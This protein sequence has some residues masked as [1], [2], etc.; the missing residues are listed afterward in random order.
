MSFVCD[1]LEG[2]PPDAIVG[3]SS[4]RR[5]VLLRSELDRLGRT[6]VRIEPLR[7]NLDTRL[8]KLDEGQ[9]HAIVLAAAGLQRLGL[10]SR[11]RHIF[12]PDQSLPAA[13]QGALG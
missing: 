4:L 7:G 12:E 8:R 11:I 6:D 2:L 9:Y 10:E 5:L 13:G 3:T 1:G